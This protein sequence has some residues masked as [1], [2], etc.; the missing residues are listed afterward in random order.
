MDS[1]VIHEPAPAPLSQS[2]IP[3]KL[4]CQTWS[5]CRFWR[6]PVLGTPPSYSPLVSLLAQGSGRKHLNLYPQR[7]WKGPLLSSSPSSHGQGPVQHT[8]ESGRRH[9]HLC[10]Q[11]QVCRP[12]TWLWNLQQC[13]GS[14][15]APL[16]HCPGIVLPTQEPMQWP[17]S[18][19]S[20]GRSH[21]CCIPGNR[22]PV[23]GPNYGPWSRCLSQCHSTKQHTRSSTIY[24]GTRE[25]PYP[26]KQPATSPPTSDPT[27]DPANSIEIHSYPVWL[28]LWR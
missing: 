8:Q 19:P 6:G 3:W 1:E 15:P 26:P 13:W 25:D 9:T 20:R 23:R 10:L 12:Q 11:S 5:D 2:G 4:A 16:S 28:L 14:V 17:C 18:S 7:S 24:P 22:W 27:A 21:T